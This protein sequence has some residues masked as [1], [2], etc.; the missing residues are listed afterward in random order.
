MNAG[1]YVGLGSNLED[2]R[3]QVISAMN[4]L[5]GLSGTRLVRRSSLYR[6][7]PMGPQDQPCFINAVAEIDTALAPDALLDA[8]QDIEAAHG[9]VRERRWGPRTLD[10]DILIYRDLQSRSER[11]SIPH[12]GL[13]ERA[14]VLYPLAE[15]EPDLEVPGHGR[16]R[17]LLANI[18]DVA[19]RLEDAGAGAK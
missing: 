2:P 8:L 13:P 10:L 18:T 3:R 17:D 12:P 6:S 14:F 16:V 5:D 19:E 1:I 15:L 4:A 11:L 7:A 9:R